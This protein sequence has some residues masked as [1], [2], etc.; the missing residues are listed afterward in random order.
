[1]P[2]FRKVLSP[3]SARLYS[4]WKVER[5]IMV[6]NRSRI[7]LLMSNRVAGRRMVLKRYTTA[8]HSAEREFIMLQRI[9]HVPTAP[10]IPEPINLRM[11]ENAYVMSWVEGDQ[12]LDVCARSA[13]ERSAVMQHLGRWISRFHSMQSDFFGGRK[14]QPLRARALVAQVESRAQAAPGIRADDPRVRAAMQA[15]TD[16]AHGMQGWTVHYGNAFADPNLRNF[17]ISRGGT[18]TGIDIQES[19]RTPVAMNIASLLSRAAIALQPHEGD[20]ADPFDTCM[21][22]SFLSGYAAPPFAQCYWRFSMLMQA[23][24]RYLHHTDERI[25]RGTHADISQR[26]ASQID[27]MLGTVAEADASARRA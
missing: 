2:Y 10:A 23:L 3:G 14:Q 9:W 25:L 15:L 17:L 7:S 18:P 1:M 21:T 24:F 12:A 19:G 20:G 8:E 22:Q 5:D 6:T 13:T 16:L 11:D 4:G 26:A 27:G